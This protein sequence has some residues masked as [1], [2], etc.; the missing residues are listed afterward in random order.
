MA[1]QLKVLLAGKT[2]I[3]IVAGTVAVIVCVRL[4]QESR[5]IQEVT[6][7]GHAL[8]FGAPPCS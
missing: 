4:P 7:A 6:N 2:R 3:A 8:L 5:F 1:A